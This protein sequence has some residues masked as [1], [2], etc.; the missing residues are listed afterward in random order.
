MVIKMIRR[1]IL[2]ITST[3]GITLV[4]LAFIGTYSGATLI[5][6]DSVYQVLAANIVVQ[7]GY[8]LTQRY[9][10]KYAVFEAALDIGYTIIV[11]ITFG[12]IFHWFTSTPI[13]I[14]IIMS[15]TIYIAG[16]L[17]SMFRMRG[18]INT[19]NKLLQE[20]RKYERKE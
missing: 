4:M 2:N 11:L 16:L 3:T 9:E 6:I 20:R 8:L 1:M 18:E 15:V 17:L 10:S 7:M 19:I 13:W 5:C 12:F 14:L